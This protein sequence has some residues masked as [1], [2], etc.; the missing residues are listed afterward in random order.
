M[1]LASDDAVQEDDVTQKF[2]LKLRS[3]ETGSNIWKILS[4]VLK[5]IAK[6]TVSE[7]DPASLKVILANIIEA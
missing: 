5:K 2:R 4:V 6:S 3:H 7:L 1:G